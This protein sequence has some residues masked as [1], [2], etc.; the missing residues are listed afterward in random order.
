MEIY[1]TEHY[2]SSEQIGQ[3]EPGMYVTIIGYQYQFLDGQ[4][5]KNRHPEGHI[6]T[7]V[8]EIRISR[9]KTDKSRTYFEFDTFKDSE[10]KG[11]IHKELTAYP[12]H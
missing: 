1:S 4:K 7:Q 11:C 3:I 10:T 12:R 6:I 2:D 5:K 8:E 9:K